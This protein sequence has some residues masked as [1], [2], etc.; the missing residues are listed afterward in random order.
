MPDNIQGNVIAA[1]PTK[2]QDAIRIANNLMD[3]KL[4]GYARSDENKRRLENNPRDNRG[5][6]PVFKRQNVEGQNVARAYTAGNNERKGYVGT[7]PYCNK[8]R[9]HHEGLCT[10]RCGNC[11]RVGHMTRDCKVTVTPNTQRAAV[12]NQSGVICYE[13]GRPGH[14]RKDCPKLRNQNRGN[15]TRNKT[16]NHTEGN[17]A[18]ARAYA[19][20]GG[21]TNPDSNIVMG[22]FLLNNCYA[23]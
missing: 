1:E 3:Q 8:C 12:G 21:G 13:C 2:V 22:T 4:K 11:K 16:G 6:Q 14:F 17:E 9:M 19:I 23:S 7:L 18:T 15:Q 5:Q 10:A 20:G